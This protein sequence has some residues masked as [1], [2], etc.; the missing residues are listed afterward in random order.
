M[1]DDPFE[2]TQQTVMNIIEPQRGLPGRHIDVGY[3]QGREAVLEQFHREY[4]PEEQFLQ[5]YAPDERFQKDYASLADRLMT[6]MPA[7]IEELIK[8]ARPYPLPED[9]LF[10]LAYY[11]GL[12]IDGDNSRFSIN[13]VGP[14]TNLW[15][16]YLLGER[17]F[18]WASGKTGWQW[19]G[20]LAFRK[21]H[22]YE[23]QRVHFYLDLAGKVSQGCVIA[24]T[25]AEMLGSLDVDLLKTIP[26]NP[27]LWTK[28]AD[29]FTDWLKRAAETRGMFDF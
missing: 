22:P 3:R 16:G 9:Y 12:S 19:L 1:K 15:Y 20:D 5:A 7:E 10:F 28:V 11:G 4:P 8:L 17:V 18:L 2:I 25:S 29:S 23:G 6:K 14:L 26:T 24:L 13:G 27:G 21:G